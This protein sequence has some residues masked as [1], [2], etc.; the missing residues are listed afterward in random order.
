MRIRVAILD[1]DQN[2][3]NRV[4]VALRERYCETLE[5]FPCN[6]GDDILSVVETHDIQVLAINYMLKCDTSEIPERCAIIYLT[7]TKADKEINGIPAMC[8]Y[9][10]VGKLYKTL[11]H[12][13]RDYDK[14]LAAKKEA[15]RKAEEERL[16]AERKAE[17]ER[18]RLEAER[19]EA[20]RKAEE[21]RLEAE[22]KAEAERLEAERK[23][24]E[25]RLEAER[26]AAE[27]ERIRLEAERKAEE[28]RIAARRSNPDIYA[29]VSAGSREGSTTASI[30]FSKNDFGADYRVLYLDLKQF[31]SMRRFFDVRETQVSFSEVLS[32]AAKEELTVEDLEK[33]I[34]YDEDICVDFIN[35]TDC[36]FELVMLGNDGF[37]NLFQK[38]GEMGKYDVVIMNLESA[39][40]QMNFSVM[41]AAKKVIFVSSGSQD[42]NNNIERNVTMI[43]RY[44]ELNETENI[45]KVNILYN[46]F[47]RRNSTVLRLD[48]VNIVGNI[49]VIKEKTEMKVIETMSKLAVFRKI[50]E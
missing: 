4:L 38:I 13:G 16:E 19:L 23:A 7:E 29:F 10:K 50:V 24:E 45:G 48:G 49:D 42:S 44:D 32:K 33:A 43:R 34:L 28:E 41:N 25:E 3:Q 39:I 22:R 14:M 8:K 40:S 5:V 20:E 6:G 26:K 12:L 11:Y 36:A 31:S 46:R 30:A 35:N 21:E 17:E 2:Y 15:E 9:Q 37:R 1:Q 27:E 18:K 47:S